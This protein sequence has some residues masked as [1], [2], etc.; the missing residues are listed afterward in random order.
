[1]LKERRLYLTSVD[2]NFVPPSIEFSDALSLKHFNNSKVADTVRVI[3][4]DGLLLCTTTE[5][6]LV[7]WSPCLGETR[8]IK[9]ND[10]CKCFR[11]KA[12]FT[13]GYGNNQSC[14]CYKILMFLDWYDISGDCSLDGFEI[15]DFNS[16]AWRV[17]N[18]PNCFVIRSHGVA[19]KGNAYWNAYDDKDSDY[20]LSFDFTRERFIR[21]CF[22]L[23][24]HD[25]LSWSKSFEVDYGFDV[26]TSLLIDE[27][28]KVALCC[29]SYFREDRNVVCTLGE[30]DKYYTEIAFKATYL[31]RP[32]IF[33]YVPSLVQIQ[34]GIESDVFGKSPRDSE[35]WED[36]HAQLQQEIDDMNS[37]FEEWDGWE[38][39]C[40]DFSSLCRN[41]G[42]GW[43]TR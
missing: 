37:A 11:R 42:R 17:V 14:R 38:I 35:T 28:K 10:G 9:H 33:N 43:K 7:V 26:Y 16:N 30:E 19:L 22:P 29:S 36:Y 3:H 31:L 1:M 6:E 23:P 13:L 24:S 20:L 12:M 34:Q 5:G 4:C 15:Y 21:L 25:Y 2:L 8:W 18:A 40:T 32:H 27:H 41:R 39:E